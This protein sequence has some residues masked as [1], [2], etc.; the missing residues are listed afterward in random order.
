MRATL[1]PYQHLPQWFFL[2]A[3]LELRRLGRTGKAA[4]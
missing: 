1:Y 3:R 4:R 2:V